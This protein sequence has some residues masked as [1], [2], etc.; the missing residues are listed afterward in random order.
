MVTMEDGYKVV[1]APSNGANFDDLDPNPSF[2]VTVQFTG[3][4]LAN[5]ASDPLHIFGSRLV[6]SGS[7]ER[8]AL[9]SVR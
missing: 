4:Y 8:T 6:F 3:E 2:K 1:C 9:C 5:G 7:A